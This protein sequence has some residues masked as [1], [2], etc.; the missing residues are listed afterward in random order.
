[1]KTSNKLDLEFDSFDR[2]EFE[3]DDLR[4]FFEDDDIT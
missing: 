3:A 4:E 1:M 2:F